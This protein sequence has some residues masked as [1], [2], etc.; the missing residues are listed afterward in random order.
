M[1]PE[2]VPADRRLR[3]LSLL[4]AVLIAAAGMAVIWVLR[5]ELREIKALAEDDRAA[6]V[7][8]MLRLT[9][10]V[11]WVSGLSFVAAGAWI[12]WLARRTYRA[13]RF[14]PPGMRVV[15][16]TRVRT[17]TAARNIANIAFL[18]AFVCIAT[19]TVGMWYLYRL[20]ADIFR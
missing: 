2:I 6:A 13:E 5:G 1:Q 20:A 7:E 18:A 16:D 8:K 10:A 4:A 9:A 15:R 17:G 12:W 14:P 11:A 3:A 19:G